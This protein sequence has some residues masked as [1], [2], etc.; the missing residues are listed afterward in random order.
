MNGLELVQA[1]F[2]LVLAIAVVLL[3]AAAVAAVLA[4][5]VARTTGINDPAISLVLRALLVLGC[6]WAL[7][8]SWGEQIRSFAADSYADLASA[9]P[10]DPEPP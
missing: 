1:G 6:V 3:G 8:A 9:R 10:P 7:A 2:A 4:G 5:L